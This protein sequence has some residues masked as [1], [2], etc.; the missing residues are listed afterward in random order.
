M[1]RNYQCP[2][3]S[4]ILSLYD[5]TALRLALGAGTMLGL[6]PGLQKV[7]IVAGLT[8]VIHEI[9]VQLQQRCPDCGV[10]LQV[11]AQFA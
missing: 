3:C 9:L 5:P 8:L 1:S 4:K 2:Q 7:A 11:A 6:A 10:A